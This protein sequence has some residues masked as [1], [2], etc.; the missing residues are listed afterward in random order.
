[1]PGSVAALWGSFAKRTPRG[2]FPSPAPSHGST[3]PAQGPNDPIGLT[4]ELYLGALGWT[5]IS[6]YV[7]Y[8]DGSTKIGVTRGRPNE[9]SRVQPQTASLQL[10]NRDGRFSPRN[11]NG[12]WYGYLGRNT[13]VRISRTWNGVRKYRYVG[14]VPSWP[15]T[16]D[17]S[18]NDVYVPL[19]AAGQLRRLQ[20]GTTPLQS[21]MRRGVP[22]D[23]QIAAYW[24][25]E[26]GTQS[27]SLAS[28]T[29]GAAM[30]V[31]GKLNPAAFSGFI[32]SSPLPTLGTD[33]WSGSVN[34]GLTG[35]SG[36]V[37][38]FVYIPAGTIT[39]GSRIASVAMVGV[40][41]ADVFYQAS[42]GI[43]VQVFDTTGA[44]AYNSG[45]L[46]LGSGLDGFTTRI[47]MNWD[48]HVGGGTDFSWGVLTVGAG[49]AIGVGPSTL[50]QTIGGVTAVSIA[51][52]GTMSGA[53]VGHVWVQGTSSELISGGLFSWVN[54]YNKELPTS[55]LTRLCSEQGVN[56]VLVAPGEV[57]TDGVGMG[58]QL[59]DTFAN[60]VQQVP[61]ADLGL[62]YE[63]RDQLALVYR[64]RLSLYNQGTAYNPE[65]GLTLD[66]AQNQLSGPLNP[67]DDDA[68]TRNDITA[69]RISGSFAEAVDTDPLDPMSILAPPQGVGPVAT[70]Y[71]LSVGADSDLP[72]HAG[73]RLHL[74]TVNEPRYPQIMLNLRH[75]TFTGNL[76]LMNAA[77]GLD[78]GDLVV[79]K[80]PP[81]ARGTPDD[82]RLI[83]Q[84]YSETLGIFEH[85]M[86]LNCSP[87]APYR[88]AMLE[89]PVLGRADTDG[90]TLAAPLSDILSPNPFFAGGSFAGWATS[91]CS[92]SVVGT[93]GSA[94]PLPPGGPGGY[95]A[96]IVPD[97]STGHTSIT[98]SG[99]L[100]PAQP[101]TVYQ[102][103]CLVYSPAGFAAG[104]LIGIT[105]YD[106]SQVVISSSTF[107]TAAVAGG[108]WTAFSAPVTSASTAAFISVRAG[109]NGA[110]AA[111]DTLYVVAPLCWQGAVS[112]AT[113]GIQ[114]QSPL[115]TTAG[116][117]F[118]F[119]VIAGGE[120]M[121]VTAV[122]G[123][124][125]PQAFTVAR[126]VNSVAKPQT[127]GTDIRLY[128]PMILSL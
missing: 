7:Y 101:N 65:P 41:R 63:A 33:R 46:T 14:E 111:S 116:A 52:D 114:P 43:S 64:T 76:D 70:T 72:D 113:T 23:P 28:A 92:A 36:R 112:V 67:L 100:I 84:G 94:S 21:A 69:Q 127:A 83:V 91:N 77:L 90:S 31:S 88:V 9:A 119:D 49:G 66:Y 74:G 104:L 78:I 58:Y 60:L 45:T 44:S 73:W 55:R 29:G 17:Q 2:F 3:L 79:I 1:M 105:S 51:P 120:R 89:D 62:L 106:S 12:A 27:T 102:V 93:S 80:N 109:H 108:V 128:Q 82:I 125:S 56:M 38:F 37:S 24:P 126:C 59:V 99:A 53:A 110:P 86:V 123:A 103:S 118:P 61:D 22:H 97:G 107:S 81:G 48:P 54:A 117:D 75:P 26:D 50:T 57:G 8:R 122:S 40:W 35:T 5:D 85:D 6:R 115:W 11:P 98:N 87:E 18:G 25:C 47:T 124:S 32:A 95:G 68:Y 20:Q 34:A 30:I 39:A 71:S 42:G 13:Q 96:L 121:T 16:W 19:S 15:V 4:V 10:N